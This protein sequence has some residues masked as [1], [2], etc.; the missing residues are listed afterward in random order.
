MKPMA[1]RYPTAERAVPKSGGSTT[2]GGGGGELG[3]RSGTPLT[4]RL[5]LVEKLTRLMAASRVPDW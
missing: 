2:L 5:V 3:V 1:G 4:Q